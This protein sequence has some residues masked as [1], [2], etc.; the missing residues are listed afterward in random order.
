MGGM[1]QTVHRGLDKVCAQFKMTMV[2]CNLA[3]LLKLLAT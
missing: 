1:A 3:R 2:A